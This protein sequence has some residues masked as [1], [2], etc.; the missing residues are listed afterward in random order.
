[1]NIK[2]K[3]LWCPQEFPES[4]GPYEVPSL[5]PEELCPLLRSGTGL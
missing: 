3:E 2:K 1:M 5:S 4:E